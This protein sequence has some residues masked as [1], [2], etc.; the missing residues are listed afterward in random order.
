MA[1]IL[2]EIFK[3]GESFSSLFHVYRLT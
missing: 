3:R 2:S 1:M